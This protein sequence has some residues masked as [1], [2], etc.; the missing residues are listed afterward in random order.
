[1]TD[2]REPADPWRRPAEDGKPL[3]TSPTDESP[4]PGHG[5]Q[6]LW[7][8]PAAPDQPAAAGPPATPEPP[9]TPSPPAPYG[10]PAPPTPTPPQAPQPQ[11]PQPAAAVRTRA[12]WPGAGRGPPAGGL[13]GPADPAPY[14]QPP[15]YPQPQQQPPPSWAPHRPPA[16]PPPPSDGW[17][18]PRRVDAI[19]GTPFGVVQLDVP[20]VISGLAI[21]ALVAGIASILVSFI[22]VCFGITGAQ[23]GWGAWA[24]GA[25]MLLAG[26]AGGG[27]VFLGLT[28]RRQIQRPGPAPAIRFTGRGLAMSG[29]VC[30]IVGL[31]ITLLGF[32]TALLLQL[33]A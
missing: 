6:P 9:T 21:A 13:P 4:A 14:P 25:F 24:A 33:T 27:A 30:G 20:P 10:Y 28:A 7:T 18:R 11:A 3:W 19:P 2:E 5:G 32:L 23:D 8:P 31:V 26:V 17:G 16:A 12:G 22:V 1:M 15:R 29:L